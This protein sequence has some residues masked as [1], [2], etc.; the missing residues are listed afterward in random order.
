[1]RHHRRLCVMLGFAPVL[2]GMAR[3]ASGQPATCVSSGPANAIQGAVDAASPGDVISVGTSFFTGSICVT[4]PLVFAGIG[5]PGATTV[6]GLSPFPSSSTTPTGVFH[7]AANV[8]GVVAFHNLVLVG[9][10]DNTTP[11]AVVR[12]IY[13]AA[14]G[15]TLLL[16]GCDVRGADYNGAG[17]GGPGASGIEGVWSRLYVRD[18]AVSGGDAEASIFGG[19]GGEGGDA[20]LA[21]PG[22]GE[23]VLAGTTL[24]GGDGG[25]TTGYSSPIGCILGAPG[26]GG[27]AIVAPNVWSWGS[28]GTGGLGGLQRD[29]NLQVVGSASPGAGHASPAPADLTLGASAPLGGSASFTL[30]NP[31]GLLAAIAVSTTGFSSPVP[32]PGF[33]PYFLGPSP[34]VFAGG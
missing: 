11:P 31:G 10:S 25:T 23:V 7:I 33:G 34:V 13:S 1:M 9:V 6:T 19:P 16:E 15:A 12:G 5:P 4:K 17:D 32:L 21:A 18:C 20:I 8:S 22:A 2:G 30:S 26:P 28:S 14:P 3:V 24:T 27:S 29:C